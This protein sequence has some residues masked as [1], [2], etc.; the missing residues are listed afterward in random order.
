MKVYKQTVGF[1]TYTIMGCSD[2][3]P[4]EVIEEAGNLVLY[5]LNDISR[6]Q[7]YRLTIVCHQ[8]GAEI[9]PNHKFLNALRIQSAAFPTDYLFFWY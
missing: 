4:L 8:L 6:D 3:T 7:E 5:Y 1:G 2:I 9:L